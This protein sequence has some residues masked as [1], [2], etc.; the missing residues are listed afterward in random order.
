MD[1]SPLAMAFEQTFQFWPLCAIVAGTLFGIV[2]GALPGLGSVVAITIILPF[3]YA[4]GP[5]AAIALL[6]GTYC[7]SVYGGCI[8]AILINTPGTPSSAA[9]CFDGFPMA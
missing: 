3:T 4:L 7:G 2:V 6:L 1:T 9:T 5:L 8:S